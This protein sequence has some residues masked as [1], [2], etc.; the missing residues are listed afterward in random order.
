MTNDASPLMNG[1]IRYL[2]NYDRNSN[3]WFGS[4][5]GDSDLFI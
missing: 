1:N 5:Q 3:T 4:T 2:H